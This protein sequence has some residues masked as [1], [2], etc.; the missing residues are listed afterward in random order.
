MR[1]YRGEQMAKGRAVMNMTALE[2]E[3]FVRQKRDAMLAEA[4]RRRMVA[5]RAKSEEQRTSFR[6]RMVAFRARFNPRGRK[7][8]TAP[9][10]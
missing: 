8:A 5:R 3:V 6:A 9:A 7:V 2:H 10:A 4:E 1:R